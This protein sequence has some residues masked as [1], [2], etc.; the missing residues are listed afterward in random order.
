MRKVSGKSCRENQNTHL[1]SISF[2]FENRAVY[3]INVEKYG[4][5]RQA[6]GDNI[7]TG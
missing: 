2:F 4:R 5:N 3:E 6:T 7:I 1:C